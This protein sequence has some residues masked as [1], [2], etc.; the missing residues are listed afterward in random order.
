MALALVGLLCTVPLFVHGDE[1]TNT[2]VTAIPALSSIPIA[3][4][5]ART[6]ETDDSIDALRQKADAGDAKSQVKLGGLYDTGEGVPQDPAVADQWYRKAADQGDAD[7]LS[8]LAF[9]YEV[10]WGVK[11]DHAEATKL[12]NAAL[13]QYQ[14]AADSGDSA[15]QFT[16]G[17]DFEF[18][19]AVPGLGP[20]KN[21]AEAI[22][23]LGMAA[24]QGNVNAEFRIAA[25]YENG[26]GV[27]KN[28]FQAAMWYCKAADQ[29]D[30][31]AQFKAG[32][33]YYK[34]VGVE[35][36]PVL[37]SK[38]FGMAAEQGDTT[39]QGMF[40]DFYLN[41][42]GVIKNEVE[43]LA[44][45]Y[46]ST[47]NGN[48]IAANQVSSAERIY[49]A[50]II[51][52]ARQRAIQ[53]QAQVGSN[54]APAQDSST[55]TS[56]QPFTNLN[57]PKESGS[58]AFVSSD[59]L[60]LTAAHVVQ[61]AARIEVITAAGTFTASV[62]KVDAT[63][64][65]ALLKCTGDNF[66]PL[67]IAPSKEARTGT[68]VFTVG[69]PNIQIQGFDPKL[70]KGEISSEAG[71]QDDPREWQISVPIQ[72]GNSGGPLCDENGNLIGIVEST[73][74]PLTMAKVEGEIPQNVNYAVK[75]SYIL[76][77][78]DEVQNLPATRAPSN[79]KFEDTV[80]NVQKSAV[81]ILVY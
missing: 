55:N 50:A 80:D 41:G 22:K 37:A 51:E 75:S 70:T 5:P 54:K 3:N 12:N 56:S 32:V 28:P 40:G 2:P 17:C 78:L 9:A 13:R 42:L 65:V 62:V 79:A 63:N 67:P 1:S 60:V 23:Y 21:L 66:S 24:Q 57:R 34:G 76:P 52:A 44:W 35:R 29:G 47:A 8:C 4:Q 31:R 64:D 74:D 61:G 10:G 53:L 6:A 39:A 71:F 30:A 18:G 81:L 68:T 19:G 43:G 33:F 11:T 72:P 25:C 69:F 48:A 36:D 15:A 77:L 27:D 49:T 59:G 58:G 26:D 14:V 38:Y 73:L 45:L 46:V 7:G 16:L 20:E